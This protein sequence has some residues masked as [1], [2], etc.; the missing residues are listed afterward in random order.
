MNHFIDRGTPVGK[1]GKLTDQIKE[2]QAKEKSLSDIGSIFL[3]ALAI[4]NL[5]E[6]YKA[7]SHIFENWNNEQLTWER[8]TARILQEENSN[9]NVEVIHLSKNSMPQSQKYPAKHG[10]TPQ[11]RCEY[12]KGRGHEKVNC[13]KLFYDN[14]QESTKMSLENDILFLSSNCL[15]GEIILDSGATSHMTN[16]KADFV[17][18]DKNSTQKVLL[19]DGTTSLT[20]EGKGTWNLCVGNNE[21]FLGN[22]LYVPTLSTKL[23]SVSK[24]TRENFTVQFAGKLCV[25]QKN[26]VI[27][28]TASLEN[29]L[30]KINKK[31][32][33]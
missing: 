2:I 18:L 11:K 31:A 3:N 10:K 25:V 14:N 26:N 24:L 13:W 4:K 29:S 19:G 28:F 16:D 21:V 1:L 23:I 17:T 30:W 32:S 5:P 22:A 33:Q 20:S 9:E 7:V 8:I 6:K 27:V 12:C 15:A